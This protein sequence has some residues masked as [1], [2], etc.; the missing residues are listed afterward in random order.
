M[1]EMDAERRMALT[2]H[3]MA[4]LDNWGVAKKDQIGM[5]GLPEETRARSLRRYHE[6]TP[7]PDTEEVR[8]RVAHLIGI[9]QSLRTMFPRNVE[10]GGRWLNRTNRHFPTRTPLQT[11]TANGVQGLRAVHAHLDCTYAW[12]LTGSSAR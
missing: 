11:M 1:A 12:D 8:E 5:L 9:S 4:L 3:I 7:L 6:D 10:M 2:Q